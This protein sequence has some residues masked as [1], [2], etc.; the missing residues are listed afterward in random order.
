MPGV[1][2]VYADFPNA[3]TNRA[4][5]PL[6]CLSVDKTCDHSANL[7]ISLVHQDSYRYYVFIVEPLFISFQLLG[8]KM[9][10]VNVSRTVL[11]QEET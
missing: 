8:L 10:V 9:L 4:S 6:K 5:V 7:E 11:L 2:S 3:V 1:V